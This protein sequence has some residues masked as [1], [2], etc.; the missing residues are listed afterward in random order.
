MPTQ[1]TR[2]SLYW[3]T[4]D[5]VEDI[6]RYT[7]GGYHPIRLGDILESDTK[8]YHVIHKLGRGSFSTVWLARTLNDAASSP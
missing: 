1:P 8:S 4:D 6:N 7:T 2:Y 5:N 3:G